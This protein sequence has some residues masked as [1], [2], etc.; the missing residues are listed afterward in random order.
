[1]TRHPLTHQSM[2]EQLGAILNK[3]E[4][5]AQSSALEAAVSEAHAYCKCCS[6]RR[7]F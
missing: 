6:L 2:F 5:V 7:R 1:M 4:S 3:E